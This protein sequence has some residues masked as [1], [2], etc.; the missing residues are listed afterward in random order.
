M[1]LET[2]ERTNLFVIALDDRRR[3][4]R[5]H[6]LFA[7]VL[8]ARLLTEQPDLI[9]VLHGRAS[10]WFELQSDEAGAIEHALAADDVARAADLT[11][12][13][14][15]GMRARRQETTLRRWLDALPDE[16][17]EMRPLLAIA[18]AG[19]L[20]STGEVAGAERRL[21]A[22]E[23]WVPATVGDS[24]RA[25]AEAAGMV[26][27]DT[28]LLEHLPSA[29]ALYRSA[30]AHM[31]GDADASIAS[32]RAAFEAAGPDKPLERGGAAGMLALAYWARGD[33]DDAH[34]AW[35]EIGHEPRDG[36][37]SGGHPRRLARA[38]RYPDRPGSP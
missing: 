26:V 9:P 30:L 15:P 27:R 3:W 36:G 6:H 16:T 28:D 25:D 37:A 22:A 8:R 14:A 7:D 4:Y 13:A 32:A 18:H 34:M 33:L 31:L 1:T 12:L 20:L 29:L 10:R 5:Y 24:G 35:S 21:T 2:L 23:R 19:A 11:E 17:F 38:C